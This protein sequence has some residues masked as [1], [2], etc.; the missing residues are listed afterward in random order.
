MNQ[1]FQELEKQFFADGFHLGMKVFSGNQERKNLLNEV[2][3]MYEGMD[4]FINSFLQFANDNNQQTD[5]KRGCSWCC[6]QPVFALTYEIE[7]LNDFIKNPKIITTFLL[8]CNFQCAL[9]G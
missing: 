8:C 3:K 2:L 9:A 5:C 1:Y 6:H 7:V 4:H